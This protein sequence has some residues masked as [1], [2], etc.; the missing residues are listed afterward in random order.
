MNLILNKFVSTTTPATNTTVDSVLIC[1]R[2]DKCNII[3]H[4]EL[5]LEPQAGHCPTFLRSPYVKRRG[6]S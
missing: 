1:P 6:V 2:K 3:Y 5:E 4:F